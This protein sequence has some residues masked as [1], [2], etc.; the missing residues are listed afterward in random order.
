M[1]EKEKTGTGDDR[2]QCPNCDAAMLEMPIMAM[3]EGNAYPPN[4]D[5]ES[6]ACKRNYRF[7]GYE[8][9]GIRPVFTDNGPYIWCRECNSLLVHSRTVLEMV[10]THDGVTG[11]SPGLVVVPIA[12]LERILTT[13]DE[14]FDTEQSES[15]PLAD[16]IAIIRSIL[17]DGRNRRAGGEPNA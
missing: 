10:D 12:P 14:K 16:D 6:S 3:E 15:D 11:R 9:T 7:D 5:V 2:L 1:T 13:I 8:E 4:Q 17:S